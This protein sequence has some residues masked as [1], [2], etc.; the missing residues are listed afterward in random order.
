MK[1]R[2]KIKSNKVQYLQLWQK[3]CTKIEMV[4]GQKTIKFLGIY[5]IKDIQNL[6]FC[7]KKNKVCCRD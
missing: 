3:I 6:G 4:L 2:M 1:I 7:Y 5:A